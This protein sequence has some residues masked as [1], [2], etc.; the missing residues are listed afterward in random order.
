M[1]EK[2]KR[3]GLYGGKRQ[4]LTDYFKYI[5]KRTEILMKSDR[6]NTGR[7]QLNLP[8]RGKV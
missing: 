5:R 6:E 2:L 3:P 4:D 8:L 1:S 7:K